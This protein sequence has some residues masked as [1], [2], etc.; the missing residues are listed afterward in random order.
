MINPESEVGKVIHSV[1][2]RLND[3]ATFRSAFGFPKESREKRLLDAIF[4]RNTSIA[5]SNE[6]IIPPERA[7]EIERK[8]DVVRNWLMTNGAPN[9]DRNGF[10]YR[11]FVRDGLTVKAGDDTNMA[12]T[13]DVEVLLTVL[14][15]SPH[16]PSVKVYFDVIV[17][18][19][20]KTYN[21]HISFY[22]NP[23]PGNER[24]VYRYHS[25]QKPFRE[26]PEDDAVIVEDLLSRVD[27]QLTQES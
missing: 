7:D 6:V 20:R 27:S 11:G 10:M 9:E 24:A 26:M 13:G 4:P 23:N 21:L 8:A 5:R 3:T 2:D 17:K 22:A 25:G 18:N 16:D 15:T 14:E 1:R 12:S 19:L